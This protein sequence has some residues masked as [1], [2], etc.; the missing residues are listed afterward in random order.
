MYY[1]VII[2]GGSGTRLWP[3][4][5]RSR[6]KQS[7]NL[8][9]D[10]SMF[11]HAVDRLAPIFQIG[12]IFVV[13]REDQSALLSSQVP[14]LPLSNFINEPIGRGT[15][16]AI[17]LA[18]IHLK[19]KDPEAIMAVLTAD[20]F[21]ENTEKFRLSLEAASVAA[22]DGH[23]VT[24]GIR[25]TTASTG[26]GY[27]M[28]GESLGTIGSFP[29]FRVERFAEK[30]GPDKARQM[31]VSGDYAWNS[32]MFVWRVIRILEE[33][34]IQMPELFA[35]LME[36]ETSIN[37]PDYRSTLEKVW[38][39]VKEQTIDYGVMEQAR[40]VVVLPV[41]IGWMDV[42]SWASLAELLPA[43]KD[44]NIFVGPH[45]EIDTHNTMVFGGKRLVATIGVQD[46]VIVDS[47]DAVL[48][49]AKQREQEVRE[50]VE[51][52]K[53]NGDNQWL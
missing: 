44:G 34:Q 22:K 36:V 6:S 9:G 12:Q 43:D 49:C 33:F 3:L 31:V 17:G 51:R 47:D 40:D 4:S 21:I 25:P 15:A 39:Q 10:R 19:Q 20:H 41:D 14:D 24:L 8:I 29:V 11:Q 18:A 35:Q 38:S 37:K 45:E 1:A 50:I 16:P 7:L 13:T 27:I 53:Q 52:L 42:G 26:Y 46:L 48:V 5:R 28:Q 23:L 32:G 2:A 30:P